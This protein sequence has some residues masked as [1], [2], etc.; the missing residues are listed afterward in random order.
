MNDFWYIKCLIIMVF[1]LKD[2]KNVDYH[3][4]FSVYEILSV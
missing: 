4:L 2:V 1:I 3:R